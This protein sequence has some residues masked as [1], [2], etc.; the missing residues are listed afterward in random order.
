MYPYRIRNITDPDLRRI[1]DILE[2]D[3]TITLT[4]NKKPINKLKY[5][6]RPIR[7]DIFIG[8]DMLTYDSNI[9]LKNP[10]LQIEHRKNDYIFKM[11]L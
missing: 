7:R 11:E 5:K 10:L 1:M 2:K 6:L 3:R 4:K 9:S 8:F